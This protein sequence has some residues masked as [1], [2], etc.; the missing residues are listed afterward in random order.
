MKQRKGETIEEFRARHAEYKRQQ[1][2]SEA[3][4]REKARERERY[5]EKKGEPVRQYRKGN[6]HAQNCKESRLKKKGEAQFAFAC[7]FETTTHTN[8]EFHADGLNIVRVWEWGAVAVK[9]KGTHTANDYFKGT[10]IESFFEWVYARPSTKFYFHNVKFDGSYLLDHLLSIQHAT[11]FDGKEPNQKE[12]GNLAIRTLISDT[13]QW[14]RITIYKLNGEKYDVFEFDDSLKLLNSTVARISKDFQC[15][16]PKGDCDYHKIR[17]VGYVPTNEE[18][19]YCLTDCLIIAEALYELFSLG[20]VKMTIAS[21]A[22]D[23][24]TQILTKKEGAKAFDKY[25]PKLELHEDTFIRHSYRGGFTYC[26]PYFQGIDIKEK[27]IVLDVNSMYPAVMEYYPLPYGKPTHFEGKYDPDVMG[28][29]DFYF[30]R[31]V[32]KNLT[33]KEGGVPFVQVKAGRFHKGATY[34]AF[35]NIYDGTFSCVDLKLLEENYDFDGIDYIEGYAFKSKVGLLWDYLETYAEIKR[36]EKGAKRAVAKLLLNS[37][38]GKFGSSPK[39]NSKIPYW[40]EQKEL[41]SFRTVEK[42]PDAKNTVYVPYASA[43][44]SWARRIL[45]DAIRAFGMKHF[46]YCDTDSV[47]AIG[48]FSDED[49]VNLGIEIH[50]SKFG[51]WKCEAVFDRAKYLHT[52]CYMENIIEEDREPV[53]KP[54]MKGGVAGCPKKLQDQIT[55]FEMFETGLVLD[56]KLQHKTVH[57]GAL[58]VESQFQIK[59]TPPAVKDFV[60]REVYKPAV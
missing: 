1:R 13:G 30:Q 6:T 48:E 27:G 4:E 5:A 44:T 56:G 47:H 39:K 29:R 20:I 7:D 40:N 43:V 28:S 49:L 52:K 26:N 32:I 59:Q 2:A 17:P 21:S 25:F 55:S 51:A 34:T 19:E 50:P 36:T 9:K 38:Y 41:V 37:I 8:N 10:N 45:I 11:V 33:L 16:A 31:V 42:E 22:L 60:I 3:G 57:G 35:E 14:Y 23:V 53:E 15:T 24:C 18:F 12:H 58:L 54:Y 46:A